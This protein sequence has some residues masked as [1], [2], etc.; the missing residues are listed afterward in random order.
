MKKRKMLKR[1]LIAVPLILLLMVG[2]V[3]GSSYMEHQDL[4]EEE[5]SR[6]PAPGDLV[7]VNDN[8]E[9]LHVYTEGAGEATFVFMSG[10]GTA[11]PVYDFQVLYEK[12]AENH[13][14]AVVERAGYGWSDVTESPRDVNTVLEETRKALKMAG[15]EGPYVLVPHSLAGLEAIHWANTYPEEIISIIGLDPL[16]PEYTEK[17][18]E[19][20]SP[21]RLI[22]F[23]ADTGLMRN[24]PQVFEEN[25][26]AMKKGHL[27]G[28]KALAA[29]SI[30]FRRVQ[31]DNMWQE[32]NLVEDNAKTVME[33]GMPGV[34]FHA[35]ISEEN[36]D[37]NWLESI[38]LY[39]KGTD[40]ET[41]ILEGDHYIHLDFPD[42]I[43]EKSEELIETG[44]EEE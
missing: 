42:L 1:V 22:S 20:L 7:D 17:S 16:V 33:K 25:F 21:S 11:S 38:R 39:T 12:I 31:T 4:I 28:E 2:F 14:I 23:L 10:F 40:G 13:E 36:D 41:F 3:V 27:E 15:T 29:E 30:F 19:D 37:E 8:G 6:Y 18:E 32:A 9:L 5:K 35:F 26:H 43:A 24:Q 44:G 34:P